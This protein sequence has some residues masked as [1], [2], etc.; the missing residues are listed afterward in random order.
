MPR[1][2]GRK[3]WFSSSWLCIEIGEPTDNVA[4]V[5]K[6][7][8]EGKEREE[9]L[10]DLTYGMFDFGNGQYEHFHKVAE[11]VNGIITEQGGKRIVSVGLGGDD[12]CIED[13]F[14]A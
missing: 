2:R 7:F 10:R 3:I 12:Q 14:A 4:S 9:W 8:E 6:W 11:V 13:G 5:Y 1:N